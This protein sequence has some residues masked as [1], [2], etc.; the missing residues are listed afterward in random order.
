MK[1]LQ[2][3]LFSSLIKIIPICSM[4]MLIVSSNS[5]MS[6]INGQATPPQNL[7]KYRKF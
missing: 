4:V 7:K 1:N 3:K 2:T 6:K 5:T